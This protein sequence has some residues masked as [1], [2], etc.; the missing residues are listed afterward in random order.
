[1]AV[2]SYTYICVI[3]DVCNE[4]LQLDISDS[5]LIDTQTD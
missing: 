1:M 2:A 5:T 3:E 4:L